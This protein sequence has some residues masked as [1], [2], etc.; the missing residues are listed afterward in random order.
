[1]RY[2]ELWSLVKRIL[3]AI[4][5][6]LPTYSLW[7]C[8]RVRFLK[9]QRHFLTQLTDFRRLFRHVCVLLFSHRLPIGWF[10]FNSLHVQPG[11]HR[12]YL[13]REG[14]AGTFCLC[15]RF[16]IS[17]TMCLCLL[18]YMLDQP[19]V[20]VHYDRHLQTQ[21]VMCQASS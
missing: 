21:L 15:F 12:A 13:V 2:A 17:T 10:C 16:D 6:V 5:H 20:V 3:C 14:D 8:V 1:M 4:C 11:A 19:A 9:M 18:A 7:N